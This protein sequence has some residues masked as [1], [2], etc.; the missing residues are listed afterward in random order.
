MKQ[1]RFIYMEI[2]TEQLTRHV[3]KLVKKYGPTELADRLN[4]SRQTIYNM[5]SGKLPNIETLQKLGVK[6]ILEESEAVSVTK[7]APPEGSKA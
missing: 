4:I 7:H 3:E 2:T 5:K 6:L 1:S